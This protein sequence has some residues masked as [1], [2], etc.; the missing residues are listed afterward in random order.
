MVMNRQRPI[1]VLDYIPV[2]RTN[3]TALKYMEE[4]VF[5]NAAVE[6]VEGAALAES[7]LKVEEKDE[8]IRRVGTYL[9]VTEEQLDDE[10]MVAFYID[11]R[12]MFMVRQRLDNQVLRGNGTA[13]NLSGILDRTGLLTFAR[14]TNSRI[15]AVKLAMTKVELE[16]RAMP[17]LTILHHNDWDG[18]VLS[19]T[20]A[21]GYYLGSP[22]GE[23]DM[24]IWGNQVVRSDILTENTGLVG[25]FGEFTS[26]HV[27]KDVEVEF[28]R[29]SDDFIKL[30][31]TARAYARVG[32]CVYRPQAF[33]T[34]TGI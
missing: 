14:G 18:I 27:R 22:S 4:T 17:D 2:V 20:T 12:L 5:T 19:E 9:P 30:I 3:Q 13:P 8:P 34:M 1:Q 29:Q 21:G 26:L 10:P 15:D 7:T 16:G 24:R 11:G 32:L 6:G 28:G 23:F 33:C 25:A 31:M